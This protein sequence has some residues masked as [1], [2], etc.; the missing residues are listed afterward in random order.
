[1]N[2]IKERKGNLI[3]LAKQGYFNV[4]VHGSNCFCRMGSGIAKA[5][6]ENFTEAFLADMKT[7]AGDY[8]KLGNYSFAVESINDVVSVVVINAYTQYNYGTDSIKLDYEA[9][10]LCLRK[11]NKNFKHKKIGVPQIGC[12]LAG[13]DWNIVSKIIEKELVDMDVTVVYFE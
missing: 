1:M 5:V 7:I 10:T 12:G 3:E 13:G 2:K 9:L 8:N 11:I 4:I 6:K